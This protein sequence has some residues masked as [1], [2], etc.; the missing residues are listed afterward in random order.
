MLQPLKQIA[1]AAI[2]MVS[3]GYNIMPCSRP[4]L[5]KVVFFCSALKMSAR[6][7]ENSDTQNFFYGNYYLIIN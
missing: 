4:S 7:L 2:L 5:Y 1:T 3:A 6:P